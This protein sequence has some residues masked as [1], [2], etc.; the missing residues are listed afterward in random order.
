MGAWEKRLKVVLNDIFWKS[1][2]GGIQEING[3]EWES[4]RSL[5]IVIFAPS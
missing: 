2:D 1:W 3:P 5:G 4:S